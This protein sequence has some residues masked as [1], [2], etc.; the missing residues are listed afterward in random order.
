[1]L[2]NLQPPVRLHTCKVRTLLEE[3]SDKDGAILLEAVNNPLWGFKTLSNELAKRGL[4][5]TD[6][7][8]ARHRR[9]QCSCARN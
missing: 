1:M 5:I 4:V 9:Q 2:E 8:I 6:F 7:T 3:L